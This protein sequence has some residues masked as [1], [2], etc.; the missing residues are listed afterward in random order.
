MRPTGR[1]Y[2]QRKKAGARILFALLASFVVGP[3]L[4]LFSIVLLLILS[5]LRNLLLD[6]LD[7]TARG[8]AEILRRFPYFIGIADAIE[9]SIGA[10]IDYWWLWIAASATLGIIISTVVSYFV[11]GAVL[12]RLA[13]LPTVDPLATTPDDRS[14]NPL[15]LTLEHVG[16]T[17]PGSSSPALTDINFSIDRG[18]FVTVVGHNGSGKSTLTR[19][20]AGRAPSTGLLVR[21]GAAGLGHH[22]GTAVVLQRPESQILGTRVADDVVWGLQPEHVPDIEALLTEVGLGGMAM[23]E[24]SSLSGGE[25]QRLAVAAA[26]ARRPA[27]L[28]ADEATAMVDR[29][30]REELVE[31]LAALPVGTIWP[32]FLSPIIRPTPAKQTGLSSSRTAG[33]SNMSRAG[34]SAPERRRFP[35]TGRA[36]PKPCSKSRTSRTPTTIGLRGRAPRCP[37]SISPSAQVTAYWSWAATAP[38]NP[39]WPGSWPD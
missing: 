25:M 31:L 34:W 13:A 36:A 12:D 3:I 7:N 22:D 18:E 4:A 20:L 35:P 16:F 1:N 37:T 23:R 6:S 17:Y 19:L 11:L 14:I 32:L 5:P 27:L 26:L 24:T 38:E 29:T 10:I 2:R 28:I 9:S 39:H 30:G 15:P 33:R 8:V 21:P